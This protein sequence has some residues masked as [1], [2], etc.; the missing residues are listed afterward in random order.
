M[1]HVIIDS[2]SSYSSTQ[3]DRIE[4]RERIMSK[5]VSVFAEA[6]MTSYELGHVVFQLAMSV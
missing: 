5:S 4:Y 6:S 1:D 2:V 3:F